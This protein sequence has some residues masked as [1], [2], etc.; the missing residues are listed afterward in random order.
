L[1]RSDGFANDLRCPYHGWTWNL[2]GS[3]KRIP[4]AWDF[5]HVNPREYALPE[6]RVDTW[7]GFVFINMDK[8]AKPLQNYLEVIPEHFALWQMERNYV[9]LH[10]EM[11]LPGNWKTALEAFMEGYH[12][13]ETHPQLMSTASDANMQYDI[14]GENVSRFLSAFG[15]QSPYMEVP[16]SEEQL[17]QGQL[18]T[19]KS[20]LTPVDLRSL[21]ARETARRVFARQVRNSL[22]RTLGTDLS[23]LCDSALIDS[24]QYFLFPNMMLFT[25]MLFPM[26]YRFRPVE[27]NPEKCLLE[28]VIL[29][30]AR[31]NEDLPE[32]AAPFRVPSNASLTIVPNMDP[33]LGAVFDQDVSNI[34]AQQEGMRASKKRGQTLGNYQ[35][36]RV[37]QFHQTLHGYVG[38]VTP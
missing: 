23:H 18:M 8:N 13:M 29:R 35:E 14:F 20:Q 28:I 21:D 32:P 27:R 15:S 22:Q 2:D 9:H 4:C 16:V 36:I 25:G 7:G 17:K 10:V 11:E 30:R 26:V 12:I 24:A 3:L 5:P 38:V 19:D 33:A 31:D 37:R 1:R 6:A 34:R